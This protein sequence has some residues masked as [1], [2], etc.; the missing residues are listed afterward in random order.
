MSL[1]PP[2]KKALELLKQASNFI[3]V[4]KFNLNE[5]AAQGEPDVEKE[6]NEFLEKNKHF[7]EPDK[8]GVYFY[9]PWPDSQVYM[10]HEDFDKRSVLDLDSGTS[11]YLIP[12]DIIEEVD[13]E[14]EN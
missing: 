12:L 13:A 4:A 6:I 14:K 1:F 8:S 5:E 7:Y 9:I 2:F 10:E 11:N 3:D